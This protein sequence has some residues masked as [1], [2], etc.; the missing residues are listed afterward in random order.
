M[1]KLKAPF[2]LDRSFN[3]TEQASR[4]IAD[5]LAEE[6]SAIITALGGLNF[7]NYEVVEELPTTGIS[8]TTIYL[9]PSDDP[10]SGNTYDEYINLNG[11]S[12]GWEKIG[13]TAIDLS[14]YYTSAETDALL[15]EK[16]D[17]D[18]FDEQTATDTFSTINGGLLSECKVALSPNQDLHGYPEP[19]VGGASK[20]K[21]PLTVENIKAWNTGEAWSGNT[22]TVAGMSFTI[23]TDDANN[24]IGIDENGTTSSYPTLTIFSGTLNGSYTL[25]KDNARSRVY[26]NGSQVNDGTSD[27]SFTASGETYVINLFTG[28]VTLNHQIVKPMLVLSTE[29]D[30]TFAPYS[31]ICPITGHT[32]VEVGDD[33]KNCFDIST[34][35]QNKYIDDDGTINNNNVF[36][37]SLPMVVEPNE[38]YTF[39]GIYTSTGGANYRLLGYDKNDNFV[40]LLGK[41][42]A[43]ASSP[44]IS[45]SSQIPNNVKFVRV[46]LSKQSS[47]CQLEK[48]NQ[49][50]AYVPYNGYQVTVNLGGTYYSGTLDVVTGVFVPDTA[51]VDLGSCTWSRTEITSGKYRYYSTEIGYV[52]KSPE[53][54]SEMP[55]IKCEGYKKKL[56]SQYN[57]AVDGITIYTNGSIQIYDSTNNTLSTTDF[58]TAVSGIKL[59][60]ELANPTPIQLIPT[61]VKANV[62]ENHLSAPLDGQEITESKYKKMFT[63]DDVIA[64]IQSLS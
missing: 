43:S 59:V 36:M 46:S 45:I 1:A 49:A 12:A 39:S 13:S 51:G 55:N 34:C 31:N 48:G 17:K 28:A 38:Y 41:Q 11:T 44:S 56:P 9:V 53:S 16:V 6:L 63:F 33:G 23:L 62:G 40:S 57:Q 42:G 7:I 24:V 32:Q 5:V 2:A 35:I 20:N 58:G 8:T 64:Y 37:Y 47:N 52:V 26:V 19:W 22:Q 50:T 30:F 61:P 18:S 54:T 10:Q 15:D 60:Y 4:N 3:T 27:Y 14:G 21:M 29:T 25:C